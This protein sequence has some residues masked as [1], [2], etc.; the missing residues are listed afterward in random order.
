MIRNLILF[1]TGFAAVLIVIN[2]SPFVGS[3]QP[4]Q[5]LEA[6]PAAGNEV[7]PPIAQSYN[8]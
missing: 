2:A 4:K 1:A 3:V 5:K 7:N 8:L 6:S